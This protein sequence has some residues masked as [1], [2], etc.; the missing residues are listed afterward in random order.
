MAAN[1]PRRSSKS[2]FTR[3]NGKLG[4]ETRRGGLPVLRGDQIRFVA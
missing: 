3:A 2:S 1:F 4:S